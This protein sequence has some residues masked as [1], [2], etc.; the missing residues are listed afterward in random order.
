MYML[1]CLGGR[2]VHVTV[3]GRKECTF[4]C[5]WDEAM[6]MLLCLGGRNVHVTVSGR[7]EC[8]CYC[9]WEEGMYKFLLTT[10]GRKECIMLLLCQGERNVPVVAMSGW[11]ECTCCSVWKE[12]IYMLLCLVLCHCHQL[13]AD[14]SRFISLQARFALFWDNTQRVVVIPCRRFGTTCKFNLDPLKVRV[15]GC[16]ET[17]VRNCHY[18]L[19]NIPR[20][21]VSYLLL[22]GSL[23]SSKFIGFQLVKKIPEFYG[24]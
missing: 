18:T 2:N 20:K 16:P 12:G 8:T 9:V 14:E 4:Y 24:T 21:R 15:I 7:K 5:S 23:K 1:L 3:S 19:H 11:K 6:Y 10:S 13:Y 22:G 17:S